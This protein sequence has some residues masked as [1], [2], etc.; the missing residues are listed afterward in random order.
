[1]EKEE[2]QAVHLRY[3]EATLTISFL[4]YLLP[5]SCSCSPTFIP[6]INSPYLQL[7]VPGE[8]ALVCSIR[9]GKSM[10][11]LLNNAGLLPALE[12]PQRHAQEQREEIQRSRVSVGCQN[13]CLKHG[14]RWLCHNQRGMK[15]GGEKM[16]L[17]TETVC[18][19]SVLKN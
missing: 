1:M 16:Q 3:A 7:Q 17:V 10:L 8:Q 11:G 15:S 9:S 13:L 18:F 19:Q 2:K 12:V 14:V 5:G 4:H 6:D